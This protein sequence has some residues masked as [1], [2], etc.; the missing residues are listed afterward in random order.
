MHRQ[1]ENQ[2]RIQKRVQQSP[3]KTSN[4]VYWTRFL[5]KHVIT[6]A[7]IVS[8]KCKHFMKLVPPSQALCWTP[9]PAPCPKRSEDC[10]LSNLFICYN[11]T[12]T[13]YSQVHFTHFRLVGWHWFRILPKPVDWV[14]IGALL[15]WS[16]NVELLCSVHP[17]HIGRGFKSC[18][19]LRT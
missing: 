1:N 5:H 19:R 15:M 18:L 3:L 7:N 8:Y 2:W 10:G 16:H 13:L 4:N 11:G 12:K 9:W 6:R 14:R 17:H